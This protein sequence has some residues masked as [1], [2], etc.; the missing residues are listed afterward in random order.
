MGSFPAQ[1]LTNA[2]QQLSNQ[3]PLAGLPKAYRTLLPLQAREDF[4]A[5]AKHIYDLEHLLLFVQ[6]VDRD[7][8]V[9]G[10]ALQA[11]NNDEA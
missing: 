4:P 8:T 1:Q 2:H 11:I 6:K 7:Q 3:S 5:G 10:A 9:T